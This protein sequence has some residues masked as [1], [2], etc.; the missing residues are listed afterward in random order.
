MDHESGIPTKEGLGIW[1]NE[2]VVQVKTS[3]GYSN[4]S[5]FIGKISIYRIV[6]EEPATFDAV[7]VNFVIEDVWLGIPEITPESKLIIR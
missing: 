6:F 2:K 1:Q 3:L 4:F 5:N 7:I